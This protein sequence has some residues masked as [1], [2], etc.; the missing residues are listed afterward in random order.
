MDPAADASR[1]ALERLTTAQRALLR[2]GCW[3]AWADGDF[4][5]EERVLLERL[6]GRLL[7][8]SSGE[9]AAEA[10]RA[11]AAETVDGLDPARLVADLTNRDDR[12][13]AVKLAVMLLAVQR[14]S[15]E[16]A[17]INPAERQAYRR[18]L[19][20]L[21]LPEQEVE[22]AEWAARRDLERRPSL[23]EVIGSALARFGAWP[24]L[25]SDGEAGALPPGPWF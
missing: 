16:E 14:H 22:E 18:L 10:A 19:E 23:R 1:A 4:A 20:L 9:A 12:Q 7:V 2:I 8:E 6:A 13:M 3:V 25:E 17:P 11:L 15:A 24:A 5:A 21:E